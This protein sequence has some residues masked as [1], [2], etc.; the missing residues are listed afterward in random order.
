MERIDP[1]HIIRKS[2]FVGGEPIPGTLVE[3]VY[4][5]ETSETTFAIYE[6]SAVRYAPSLPIGNNEGLTPYSA[7]NTLVKNRIVLF[8]SEAAEYQSEAQLIADIRSF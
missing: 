6:D 8:P 1:D 3:M 5:P 2:P 7:N 4:R